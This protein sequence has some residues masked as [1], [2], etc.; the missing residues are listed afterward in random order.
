MLQASGFYARNSY[1]IRLGSQRPLLVGNNQHNNV[2]EQH[3]QVLFKN[4]LSIL[5]LA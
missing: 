4:M 5:E 2:Q 3:V 1:G